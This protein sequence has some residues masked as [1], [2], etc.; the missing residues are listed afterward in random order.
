MPRRSTAVILADATC[1]FRFSKHRQGWGGGG[2]IHY[3]HRRSRTTIN[4]RILPGQNTSGSHRAGGYRVHKAPNAV[5]C[6]GRRARGVPGTR[7][8]TIGKS[9]SL[10]NSTPAEAS[11][12]KCLH[13]AEHIRDAVLD[14]PHFLQVQHQAHNSPKI[15]CSTRSSR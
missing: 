13:R 10:F 12:R 4:L 6:W 3:T 8:N 7:C 2:G 9:Q 1:T 5:S 14:G 11:Q 15:Y